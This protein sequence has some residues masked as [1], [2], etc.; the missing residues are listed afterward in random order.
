MCADYSNST[1]KRRWTFTKEQLLRTRGDPLLFARLRLFLAE[2]MAAFAARL[3]IRQRVVATGQVFLS[4]MLTRT[5]IGAIN[6]YL[7][8]ATCLYVSSRAEELPVHMRTI[9]S[10]ARQQWPM[11]M[12]VEAWHIAECEFYVLAEL[13]T[14]LVVYHPYSALVQLAS[15]LRLAQAELQACWAVVNDSY[16]TDAPLLY[17]PHVIAFTAVYMVLVL[18]P[19]LVPNRPAD[20]VKR[21]LDTFSRFMGSRRSL[22]LQAVITCIQE[23]LSFYALKAEFKSSSVADELK[24]LL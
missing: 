19:G 15:E 12:P 11:Y 3:S 5:E 18:K 9:S 21:R 10:E 4:R 8:V 23:L 22:D 16:Y 2:Q 7:L 17:A 20:Q 14:S 1:Q 24:R 6:P 13:E